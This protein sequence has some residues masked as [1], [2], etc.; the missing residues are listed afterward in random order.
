MR[1][2]LDFEV[3]SQGK[4]I[5]PDEILDLAGEMAKLAIDHGY[6]VKMEDPEKDD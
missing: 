6:K 2:F 3:Q 1:W 5:K 4:P